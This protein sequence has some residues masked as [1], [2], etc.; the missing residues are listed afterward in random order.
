MVF[1]DCH[2]LCFARAVLEKAIKK[3]MKKNQ[4]FHAF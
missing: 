1:S 4:L 2:F 3:G